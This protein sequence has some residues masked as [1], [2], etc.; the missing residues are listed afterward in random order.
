M[1]AFVQK[2]ISLA[3]FVNSERGLV[4]GKANIPSRLQTMRH[5]Q[6]LVEQMHSPLIMDAASLC[7]DLAHG[8]AVFS[9]GCSAY[10][11]SHM[12]RFAS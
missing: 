10:V 6:G 5:L 9:T 8:H 3:R 4:A 11:A 2:P 1:T 7:T 12:L